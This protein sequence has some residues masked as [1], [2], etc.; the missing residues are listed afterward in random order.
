LTLVKWSGKKFAFVSDKIY[1]L[2]WA[3]EKAGREALTI[4]GKYSVEQIVPNQI[5]DRLSGL[6]YGLGKV[7]KDLYPRG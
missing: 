4:D 6:S 2:I 3:E 5:W 1:G 7:R